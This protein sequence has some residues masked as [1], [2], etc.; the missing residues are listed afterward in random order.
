MD[1]S[2]TYQN[3]IYQNNVLILATML[4]LVSGIIIDLYSPSLPSMALYFNTSIS[5]IKNSISTTMYGMSVG[6]LFFGVFIDRYGCKRSLAIGLL[7]FSFFVFIQYYQNQYM[8]FLAYAS[9]KVFLDHRH[10][11]VPEHC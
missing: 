9:S 1:Q 5:L 2:S 11:L 7:G 10:S 6:G 8:N 3:T 4:S